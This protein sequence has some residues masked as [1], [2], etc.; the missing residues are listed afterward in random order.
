MLVNPATVRFIILL[1]TTTLWPSKPSAFKP[2]LVYVFPVY[3]GLADG[4]MEKGV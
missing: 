4:D 1:F 2:T 3:I